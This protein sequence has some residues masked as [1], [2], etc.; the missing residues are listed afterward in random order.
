MVF[1]RFVERELVCAGRP[2]AFQLLRRFKDPTPLVNA[3]AAVWRQPGPRQKYNL[4]TTPC[5]GGQSFRSNGRPTKYSSVVASRTA[6]TG[7]LGYHRRFA[8]AT[9]KSYFVCF[10]G[11]SHCRGVT[12]CLIYAP[13]YRVAWADFVM[14][15]ATTHS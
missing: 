5:Q 3:S 10:S 7:A 8:Y 15:V 1:V 11:A 14:L 12:L 9:P 6:D 13:Q 2:V 4:G